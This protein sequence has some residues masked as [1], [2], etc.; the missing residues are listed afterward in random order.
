[1]KPAEVEVRA[2]FEAAVQYAAEI[3]V[4]FYEAAEAPSV[5]ATLEALT[6]E[7]RTARRA[8]RGMDP[9]LVRLH[10]QHLIDAAVFPAH[11]RPEV[12]DPEDNS[13]V[14]QADPPTLP[15][16]FRV[17]RVHPGA[18]PK[19]DEHT[20]AVAY[21]IGAVEGCF[22]MK[23]YRNEQPQPHKPL[24]GRLS[25]SDAVAEAQKRLK[26]RPATYKAV[27]DAISAASGSRAALEDGRLRGDADRNDVSGN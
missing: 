8:G 9:R 18:K 19:P 26:R 11:D 1:M 24:E 5:D 23:P 22:G 21:A 14:G 3:L 4:E 6:H 13:A 16:I 27:I 12:A 20:D 2:R 7:Y 17:R 25:A 15:P 10:V